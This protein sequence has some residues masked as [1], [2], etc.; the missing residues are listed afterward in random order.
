M[1]TG[2][3]PHRT[4]VFENVGIPE[5]RKSFMEILSA[6]GYQ[7][8]G[9]GKMHFTFKTGLATKWGFEQRA[10]SE[11][12]FSSEGDTFYQNYLKHGYD[13]VYEDKGSRSEM[14]YIPQVS[15]LPAKLHHTSW[16]V[17]SCLDF[18]KRQRR[19]KTIFYDDLI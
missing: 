17:D 7:T 6:N 14:Y 8:F 4:G 18:L 16:T 3:M 19:R 10:L 12:N 1:H 15:Q 5:G 2:Q 13:H 11:V 9:A